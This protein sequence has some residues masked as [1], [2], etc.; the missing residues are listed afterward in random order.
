MRLVGA[1]AVQSTLSVNATVGVTDGVWVLKLETDLNGQLGERFMEA[2]TCKTVTNAA[3]VTLALMLNPSGAIEEAV[4][5]PLQPSLEPAPPTEPA[6]LA[7]PVPPTKP[8]PLAKPVP[9][10]PRKQELGLTATVGGG[11]GN[12][13][14]PDPEVAVG[15]V[16]T[17][18]RWAILLSG[19]YGLPQTSV[20][21]PLP[22]AANLSFG[23]LRVRGCFA[24]LDY[25][26]T[27]S[28]CLGTGVSVLSGRGKGIESPKSGTIFWAE[29]GGGARVTVPLTARLSFVGLVG[30]DGAAA[31]RSRPLVY[32]EDVNGEPSAVRRAAALTGH[33]HVGVQWRIW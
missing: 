31:P 20:A 13:P 8:A 10:A 30:A 19:V 4:A 33:A 2:P 25:G 15:A 16:F 7:K 1:V 22:A 12:L 11:L 3:A 17:V 9:D 27:L 28:P 26:W 14:A 29:L 23:A 32:I 5:T 6:P 21:S 24:L 18:E